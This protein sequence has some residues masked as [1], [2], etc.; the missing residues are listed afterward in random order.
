MKAVP[1]Q[2]ADLLYLCQKFLGLKNYKGFKYTLNWAEVGILFGGFFL[3]QMLV[4]ILVALMIFVFKIDYNT[5][6]WFQMLGYVVGFGVPILA[7]DL[8]V[9][10]PKRDKL[11]FNFSNTSF[12]TWI[13][14]LVMMFG[15]MLIS[16]FFTGLLPTEGF[17]WGKLYQSFMDQMN[18]IAIDPVAL[19]ILVAILAPIFEEILF[20]GII[21]KGLLNRGMNAYWAIVL[22]SFIFG[23]VHFYPWQFLGAFLL[24]LVL[25]L[26]YYKTKS[27]LLPIMMHAFNN[28][29]AAMMIIYVKKDSF[30]EVFQSKEIYLLGVGIFLLSIAFYAFMKKY[31]SE[32][33]IEKDF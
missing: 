31:P 20:R 7:F 24:G 25:G 17:F 14:I 30:A 11:N 32:K 23:A 13:F 10:R 2:I 16:E 27:L 21:M 22:S 3:G 26:V 19:V 29:L 9:N 4:A 6:A 15:M 12:P 1:L 8:F 5:S 18:A 28:F 33:A